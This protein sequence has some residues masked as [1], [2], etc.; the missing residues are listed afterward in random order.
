MNRRQ[1]I[2]IRGGIHQARDDLLLRSTHHHGGSYEAWKNL[3]GPC[4]SIG[5]H[6]LSCHRQRSTSR[7][8]CD[9]SIT[10]TRGGHCGDP[11]LDSNA[12]MRF[13]SAVSHKKSFSQLWCLQSRPTWLKLVSASS[14]PSIASSV[15]A[16]HCNAIPANSRPPEK[17]QG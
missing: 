2:R 17:L 11:I 13:E 9:Q 4:R 14:S 1:P 10:R 8:H 15:K 7:S 3:P 16:P 5:C 6:A 12:P